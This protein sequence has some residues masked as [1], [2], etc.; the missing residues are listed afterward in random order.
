[1]TIV[2]TITRS[3]LYVWIYCRIL[4]PY[5]PSP[6]RSQG[7][8]SIFAT[9]WRH[10]PGRF[11][12]SSDYLRIKNRIQLQ[13]CFQCQ[14]WCFLDEYDTYI[15]NRT[16]HN[17]RATILTFTT[18]L[19]SCT[20]ETCSTGIKVARIPRQFWATAM[21]FS[22]WTVDDADSWYIHVPITAL[23]RDNTELFPEDVIEA[24]AEPHYPVLWQGY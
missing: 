23:I 7:N 3:T 19:S 9:S 15:G 21:Q 12:K 11:F 17:S 22:S 6:S 14:R 10:K 20:L 1:M 8:A 18:W 13:L 24:T 5:R 4:T 16:L 2:D